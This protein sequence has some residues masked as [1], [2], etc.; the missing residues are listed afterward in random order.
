MAAPN[1]AGP[2]SFGALR[3]AGWPPHESGAQ[4]PVL[5]R[6][7]TATMMRTT[8]VTLIAAS[9]VCVRPLA[10]TPMQ[11]TSA[12]ATSTATATTCRAPK[13]QWIACP[14]SKES[15]LDP[16]ATEVDA[17]R[18]EKG[19][20]RRRDG[21]RRTGADDHTRIPSVLEGYGSSVRRPQKDVLPAGLGKHRAELGVGEGTG[22][23]QEARGDPC[24]QHA[25]RGRATSCAMIGAL[26]EHT[27]AD[28]D[29]H[30]E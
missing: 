19:G 17:D 27:R 26:E 11:F 20:E 13:A 12:T 24:R 16:I 10:T 22:E 30:D 25:E 15:T 8:A 3:A 4:V 1:A 6:P 5:E 2:P 29:A 7:N 14:A 9:T 21:R 18:P 23:G 28:D